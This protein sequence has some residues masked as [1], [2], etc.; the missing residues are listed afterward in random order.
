MD[1]E[2]WI[3]FEDWT[4]EKASPDFIDKS[5]FKEICD[6]RTYNTHLYFKGLY[7][8]IIEFTFDNDKSGYGYM[9]AVEFI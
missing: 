4:D 5:S 2:S 8:F 7:N 1:L 9:Y 3:I 6:Y